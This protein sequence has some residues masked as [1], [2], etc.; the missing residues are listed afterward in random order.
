L[1]PIA[2]TK[3]EELLLFPYLSFTFQVLF[4]RSIDSSLFFLITA[5]E[6]SVFRSLR[7][8]KGAQARDTYITQEI[9]ERKEGRKDVEQ[10]G[11]HEAAEED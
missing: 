3:P 2:T 6:L 8:G 7:V 1:I 4:S 11:G 10:I 5:P 9:R